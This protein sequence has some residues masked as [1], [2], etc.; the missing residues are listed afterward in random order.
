MEREFGDQDIKSFVFIGLHSAYSGCA[1]RGIQAYKTHSFP[2]VF[3]I[4]SSLIKLKH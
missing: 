4:K 2:L 3:K 1:A